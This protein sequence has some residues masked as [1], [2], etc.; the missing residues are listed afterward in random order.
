MGSSLGGKGINISG[1]SIEVFSCLA[2]FR[3]GVDFKSLLVVEFSR[4]IDFGDRK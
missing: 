1:W 4:G 2:K 3:Y